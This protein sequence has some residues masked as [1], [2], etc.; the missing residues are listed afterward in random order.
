MAGPFEVVRNGAAAPI[1]GRARRLLVLLAVERAHTVPT[2]R[3]VEVL[4]ND[5]PPARPAQNVAPLVSR[6]RAALGPEVI[7]R[8]GEGYRLGAPPAVEVDLD[9][10]A[11]LV[12]QARRLLSTSAPGPAAAA[13]S[14]ALQVLGPGALLEGEPD[15]D[16]VKE[17]RTGGARLLRDARHLAATAALQ[18][19]DPALGRLA[20]EAAVD[21]DPV[22][23]AAWRLLLTAH[24]LAGEPARA[25]AAYERLRITL[26]DELGID[27]APPTRALHAALLREQDPRVTAELQRPPARQ[28]RPDLVGRTTELDRLLGLWAAGTTGTSSL[29]LLA[30]EGGIGK[31]RL[32]AEVVAAAEAAGGL[33][34]RAR[35][36]AGERSLFL[37]PV[38]DAVS[39]AL[40]AMPV[41]RVRELAG[42]RVGPLV[43]LVPQLEAVLG[44]PAVERRS[45]EMELRQAYEAVTHVLGG[46]A[47][48]RAVLV[49]LDDLHN[50]G[51]ATVE[52]LHY[53]AR[54]T[55]GTRLMVLAT[56]RD[57]EGESALDA[58]AEVATRVDLGPLPPDAVARLARAAGRGELAEVI[59]RRTRGHTLFVVETLRALAAGDTAAPESLQAVVLARLRRVGPATE[60]VLRAG[61]VLGAT[62]DVEVVAGLLDLPTHLANQR[63]GVAVAA[64]LLV[65]TDRAYDFANDLVQEVVYATTPGPTRLA[66]HRRAAVLLAGTPEPAARH[67]EAVHDWPG[68][69]EGY[70]RAAEQAARRFAAADAL[71][72]AARA[73]EVARRS[74]RPE[75]IARAH[76]LRGRARVARAEFGLALTDQ[77]A[78][79]AAARLA[80]DRLLEMTALRELGGHASVASQDV[81]IEQCTGWLREGVRIAEALGDRAMQARLLA[82]LGVV[83]SNRLS[84]TEALILAR[85]AVDAGRQAGDP[86]ALA[87]AL[88]GLKNA[89][90]YLG[91]L[92]PLATVIDEL[93]PLLRA[94]GDL[95]L[96]QWTVYESSFA[97]LAAADWDEAERRIRE[98]VDINHRAGPALHDSWFL[99]ELGAVARRRGRYEQAVRLGQEALA[100][101]RRSPHRWF[102][103]VAA[104]HLGTTLI[105]LRKTAAAADVLT[106]ASTEAY[107]DGAEANLLRC[108]APLAQA[109]GSTEILAEADALLKVIS[110]PPGSAWLLGWD[111][112]LSLA[113]AWLD[114]RRPARAKLILAPLID[115]A[116]RNRWTPPLVEAGVVE[117]AAMA[118][119]GEPTARHALAEAITLASRHGMPG[120]ERTARALLTSLQQ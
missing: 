30:G 99:A 38:V 96:L 98:A 40:L 70:L 50:A 42:P 5:R 10:A 18:T 69:A 14:R 28:E 59:Q 75:L 84:F 72:L 81:T 63:C 92:V 71:A 51:L 29:V 36:Y 8:R 120:V 64:R 86:A 68:A 88:D 35:C 23:E 57:E 20:A 32:A 22:D 89:H 34:L 17:A 102:G 118:A 85:R 37:Q 113:R 16:W 67:A 108:L 82:W 2:D 116:R 80:G 93:E 41:N 61:A 74:E 47:A 90:A 53:L 1:T 119:L 110:V 3:I 58:L 107:R 4:W 60:E 13:A 31:T 94:L 44:R 95:E 24:Q 77:R 117:A 79:L 49:F 112:Y 87:A 7:L 54:R 21:A 115:A 106:S 111:V 78:G 91:E 15:A 109:T 65:A 76:L 62:I 6:L 100:V 25:L 12:E 97:A 46:L 105:E 11:R 27:P 56:I 9:E 26:A 101:A 114:Q 19:G 39:P 43:S 73:L 33:V 103:P 83:A 104:A 45:A 52:L 55:T 48:Q 66:H